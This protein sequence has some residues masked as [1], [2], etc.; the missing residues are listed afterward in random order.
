[1]RTP[2][3]AI[4]TVRV[5][6]QTAECPFVSSLPR[7]GI[8]GIVFEKG[9]FPERIELNVPL[10]FRIRGSDGTEGERSMERGTE[11]RE[12]R[13]IDGERRAERRSEQFRNAIRTSA[14]DESGRT[15]GRRASRILT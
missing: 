4:R 8:G 2:T 6:V 11:R 10:N 3:P 14:G 7:S 15:L 9:R 5:L 1:M 12:G 13:G